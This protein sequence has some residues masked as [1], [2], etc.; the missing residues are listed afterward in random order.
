MNSVIVASPETIEKIPC[1]PEADANHLVKSARSISRKF[2]DLSFFSKEDMAQSLTLAA[3]DRLTKFNPEDGDL[4]AFLGARMRGEF[5]DQLRSLYS[6][7]GVTRDVHKKLRFLEPDSPERKKLEHEIVSEGGNVAPVELIA[8]KQTGHSDDDPDRSI[9][10]K[11][12]LFIDAEDVDEQETTEIFEPIV[13]WL[14]DNKNIDERAIGIFIKYFIENKSA[15]SIAASLD[16]SE[17]SVRKIIAKT[18]GE[19]RPAIDEK[20]EID[21]EDQSPVSPQEIVY[22][23]ATS[24]PPGALMND[25]E[26]KFLLEQLSNWSMSEIKSDDSC[27]TMFHAKLPSRQLGVDASEKITRCLSKIDATAELVKIGDRATISIRGDV[28]SH[29]A[30][31]LAM[32]EHIIQSDPS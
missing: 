7:Q 29:H 16:L 9:Y 31:L 30:R 11:A 13:Q 12:V 26:T 18:I 8:D 4:H 14:E 15:P 24:L 5:I 21:I 27:I 22:N 32:V 23:W 25:P 6:E 10:D 19:L 28:R 1:L 2:N 17:R 20:L 3:L